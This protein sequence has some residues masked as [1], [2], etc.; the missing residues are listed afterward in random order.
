MIVLGSEYIKDSYGNVYKLV[1]DGRTIRGLIKR[2][3]LNE[4]KYGAYPQV[5]SD[6]RNIYDRKT[7]TKYTIRYF[8]GSIYPFLFKALDDV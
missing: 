4:C 5:D 7:N 2:G 3:L 8:E 6:N 1:T